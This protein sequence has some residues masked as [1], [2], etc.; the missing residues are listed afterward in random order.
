MTTKQ[1]AKLLKM[2]VCKLE[3]NILIPHECRDFRRYYREHRILPPMHAN[4][5]MFVLKAVSE[6][7]NF[8]TKT[9]VHCFEQLPANVIGHYEKYTY[10]NGESVALRFICAKMPCL[11]G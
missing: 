6:V 11:I 4:Y 9:C 2:L 1:I 5:K 10:S 7:H 3:I 8:K